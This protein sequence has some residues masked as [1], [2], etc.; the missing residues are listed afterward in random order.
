MRG[1]GKCGAQGRTLPFPMRLPMVPFLLGLLACAASGLSI[2]AAGIGRS[3][4][5]AR[6]RACSSSATETEQIIS[7]S[8]RGMRRLLELQEAQGGELVVRMGVRDGNS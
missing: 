2:G 6:I 3:A 7:F 4:Q 5:R 1:G 8:E